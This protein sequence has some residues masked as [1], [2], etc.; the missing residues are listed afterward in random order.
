MR[1]IHKSATDSVAV[2][3]SWSSARLPV[4]LQELRSVVPRGND[5]QSCMQ[6]ARST[7]ACSFF[8]S[9]TPISPGIY[10][11]SE[12]LDLLVHPYFVLSSAFAPPRRCSSHYLLAFK[13]L[14]AFDTLAEHL[15]YSTTCFA[16][17][18]QSHHFCI[19]R[20]RST[21]L[22]L[23]P[24]TRRSSTTSCLEYHL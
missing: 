8:K 21:S 18:S 22:Q 6:P 24:P 5:A 19:T 15:L 16:A 2:S 4:A 7:L 1:E 20:A 12:L 14:H 11:S 13:R 10:L 17:A 3:I 23:A 9:K